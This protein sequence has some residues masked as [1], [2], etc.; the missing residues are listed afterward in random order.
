MAQIF[1]PS[2]GPVSWRKL[3]AK[4]ERQWRCGYSAMTLAKSWEAANGLPSE[5]A[6]LFRDYPDF[7]HATPKMLAAFPEW[8]VPL[9]G[10]NRASQSDIFVLARCGAQTISMMVEGKVDEPFG[11]TLGKWLTN[12]THGK[13]ERLDFLSA[14]LGI[15]ANPP[16]S[17][18]YQL[19]HR[20]AS[21]LI[22][23]RRFGTNAAAM[24]VHS[25]SSET[26][27]FD[28]FSA[29]CGLLGAT[30]QVGR[31]CSARTVDMPLYLGWAIGDRQFLQDCPLS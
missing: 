12:E 26:L 18:R 15:G 1:V 7:G 25:F 14:T 2:S 13:R 30:P 3:L 17:I 10:G 21:A 22:E 6:C 9:P 24:I 31:L 19:L 16:H 23:A 28:D 5:V 27:W 11:P 20:T 8:Q 4:P 29:F